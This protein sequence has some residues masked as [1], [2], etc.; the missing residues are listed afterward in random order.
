VTVVLT[1]VLAA[2]SGSW[3]LAPA[4]LGASLGLLAAGLAVSTV[5][6][7][8][9]VYPAHP[10]GASPFSSTSTGGLGLALVAQAVTSG[11]ALLLS[12]PVLVTGVLAVVVDPAW[13][14]ACLA[15]GAVGGAGLVAGGVVLGGRALDARAD[16]LLT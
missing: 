5:I 10:P 9:I 15:V 12:L 14:W 8:V 16:L 2:W 11:A 1:L 3:D 4:A 6:S 13:G 7:G